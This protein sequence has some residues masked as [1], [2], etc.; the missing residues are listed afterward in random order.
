MKMQYKDILDIIESISQQYC[1]ECGKCCSYF[2][3]LRLSADEL[4]P[5]TSLGINIA[6]IEDTELAGRTFLDDEMLEYLV[7][8]E[9]RNPALMSKDGHEIRKPFIFKDKDKY[10]LFSKNNCPAYDTKNNRCIIYSERPR[11]CRQYPVSFTD[12]ELFI[13]AECRWSTTDIHDIL[14]KEFPDLELRII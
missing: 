5:F 8:C 6:H 14:K 7:L 13:M 10:N 11:I 1:K 2:P 12:K 9:T 4:H 3:T